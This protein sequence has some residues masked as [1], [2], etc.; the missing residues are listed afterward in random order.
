MSGNAG[1]LRNA[2]EIAS[3]GAHVV[4]LGLPGSDVT[5]DLAETVI[6]KGAT[7]HG[8]TGR[9]MFET[10]YDVSAF[11]LRNPEVMDRILTHRLEAQDY[12]TGFDLIAAGKCG[13]VLLDFTKAAA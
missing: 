2:L 8:V 5:L 13:K 7:L 9:R 4:L 11:M 10:W 3:N 12:A 1:A 6:M